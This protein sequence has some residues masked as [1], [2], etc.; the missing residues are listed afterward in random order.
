LYL[1]LEHQSD[2]DQFMLLR[3]ID[4]LV[5]IYKA[6]LRRWEQRH[7]S[8]ASFRFQPVLPI[9]LYTGERRWDTLTDLIRLVE[10]GEEFAEVLPQLQP[11][12]LS[13]PTILSEELEAS[14]GFLGWVLELLKHRK[15]APDE[16]RRL[17]ARVV[18]H[19]E[20]MPEPSGSAGCCYCRTSRR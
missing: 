14:G 17:V 6:Q 18:D 3:V 13:L 5:Q 10:G 7:V 20:G 9:V 15:A 1:L 19:L 11:L 4:Y 8:G 12:F 2:V 16:F